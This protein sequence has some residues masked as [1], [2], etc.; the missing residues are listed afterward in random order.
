MTRVVLLA[1]YRARYKGRPVFF[2]RDEMAVLLRFYSLRVSEGEWR[3]Y[4]IGSDEG[5]AWFAVCR[6]TG[7]RPVCTVTKRAVSGRVVYTLFDGEHCVWRGGCLPD[8]LG[9]FDFLSG[10]QA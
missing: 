10:V 6:Y 7:E 8:V 4:A 3:D 9:R 1:G 2:S 5:Q